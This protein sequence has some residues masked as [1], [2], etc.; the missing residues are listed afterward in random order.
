MAQR[1]VR[2]KRKIKAA[3]IP[4]RIPPPHL[5]AERFDSVLSVIYL[6]FNEG[7]TATSGLQLTRA[8]LCHGAIRLGQ[9]LV[10]LAPGKPEAAGLLALLL[11]HD[12]RCRART[13]H[14]G[15]LV[16]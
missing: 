10:S 14:A 12:S 9:T 11:L 15:N 16:P 1:L 2:T 8:D 7:Y 4:Y 5:W 13:D 3:N 6:I